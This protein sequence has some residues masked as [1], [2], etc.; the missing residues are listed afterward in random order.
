MILQ[1][2]GPPE[3]A[4]YYHAAYLWAAAVYVG[5]VVVLWSRARRVRMRLR[6]VERGEARGRRD[7]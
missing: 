4:G 3:N 2:G 7:T 1:L 6:T 5:Y